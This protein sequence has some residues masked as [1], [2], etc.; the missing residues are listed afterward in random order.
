MATARVR[1]TV[2]AAPA[3]VWPLVGDPRGLPRWWPR[4][5]RVEGVDARRFTLVLR[6]SGGREVRADQRVLVDERP[7]RRV[8]GLEI[9]GTP[10]E[11]VFS[12][13]EVEVRLEPEGDGTRVELAQRMALR[14]VSRLGAPLAWQ[15]ARRHLRTALDALVAQL[16]G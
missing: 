8:W 16:G 9:A 1:A 3:E 5:V 12:A 15:S 13:Y 4:A 11:R 2:P 6:S 10:F 14:G 7:R